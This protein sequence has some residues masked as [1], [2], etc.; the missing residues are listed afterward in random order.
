MTEQTFVLP[1]L[2]EGL[3]EAMIT[4][5]KV[6]IGDFVA[7]DEEVVEVET[8][9]AAVEVPIPFAGTVLELHAR[10]G[11][12]IAVGSPLITVGEP[13]RSGEAKL[14]PPNEPGGS[15]RLGGVGLRTGEGE[16]KLG[17]PNEPGG[18]ARLGGVGLRTG[19][20]EAKLGP[21]NE[22]GGSARLGGVGL[23]TGEGEAKLG[24]PNEPGGSARLGGVGLRT[25]EGEAKLGPPNEPRSSGSVLIGYGTGVVTSSTRRR[26]PAGVVKSGPA[27][28]ISPIV[29]RLATENGIDLDGV[30]GS[31]AGGVVTRADVDRAIADVRSDAIRDDDVRIPLTGIR[32]TIAEKVTTSRREIPDATTWVDVDA[33]GLIAARRLIAETAPVSLLAL[34]ARLAVAALREFPDLN[35]SFDPH[36]KEILRHNHIHLGIAVQSPRGLVVPVISNAETL[37]TVT[38][39]DRI[40][41]LVAQARDGN[42]APALLSGGTVTL[43][44]YGVFGVDGA[45]SII[46]HPEAAI[47]GVGRIVD[48]PWVVA[49]EL[50]VRRVTQLSLT[51]DHRVCDGASAGGL[52][53]LFA[54]YVENPVAALG[55]L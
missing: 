33:T 16:A 47:L 34:L 9:K 29:R 49:G 14:G 32:T 52:L 6:D 3:K 42:I 2:G 10:A 24:P 15:A 21:P 50:A 45:A 39:S 22:P 55:R 25:G 31:G 23:R 1:D 40:A 44:N 37:D 7:V 53:R 19:E 43:N 27:K 36:S 48:R 35:S 8:A 54:D 38:L 30:T 13:G 41:A 18:S 46:N 51:F 20:G 28:V 12:T 11:D 4:C 26:R 5:W 17:P